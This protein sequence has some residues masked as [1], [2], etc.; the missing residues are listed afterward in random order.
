MSRT[1]SLHFDITNI[2]SSANFL[3]TVYYE[4]SMATK[5]TRACI[6]SGNDMPKL[7]A[8][9]IRKRDISED[10]WV[11]CPGILFFGESSTRPLLLH[12]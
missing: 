3:R 8:N 4:I 12:Q 10:A 2:G 6:P 1:Q 11:G 9:L 7:H 5:H